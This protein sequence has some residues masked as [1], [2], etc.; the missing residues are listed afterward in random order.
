MY[1]IFLLCITFTEKNFKTLLYGFYSKAISGYSIT[2]ISPGYGY[3][4]GGNKE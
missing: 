1:D 3:A 4:G 2:G